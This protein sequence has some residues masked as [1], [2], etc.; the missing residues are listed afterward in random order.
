MSKMD[1]MW[2]TTSTLK[3]DE[4]KSNLGHT[5]HILGPQIDHFCP[6]KL[7]FLLIVNN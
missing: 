7:H 4:D 2:H 5:Q 1:E 3:A 6:Q